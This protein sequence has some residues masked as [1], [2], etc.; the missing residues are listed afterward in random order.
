MLNT[1]PQPLEAADLRACL[2]GL[3]RGKTSG[4]SGTPE[5]ERLLLALLNHI[6]LTGEVPPHL[7]SALRL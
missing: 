2:L 3:R 5:G 1:N 7:L 6:F 4:G